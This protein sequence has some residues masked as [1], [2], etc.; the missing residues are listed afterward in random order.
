[1]GAWVMDIPPLPNEAESIKKATAVYKNW[2]RPILKDCQVHHIL[3]RPDGKRWDGM[4]YW[5][6][7]LRKGILFIFRPQ[8]DQASQVVRLKGLAAARR[9][10]VW[11]EDGSIQAGAMTGNE[12]MG[13]GL[14]I[15]LPGVNT[16]DLIFV[17]EE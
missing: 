13:T 11:S 17:E 15:R 1:M 16:S 3:P 2:I 6:P 7:G 10:K 8:S 9:Y 12:L 4:F 5:G 14:E